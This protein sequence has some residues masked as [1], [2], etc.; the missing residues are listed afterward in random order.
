M[1]DI[2]IAVVLLWNGEL[3]YQK[4]YFINPKMHTEE[5]VLFCSDY[6]EEEI[7]NK[8]AYHTWNYSNRGPESQGWY[9]KNKKGM[10][11]GH[12]C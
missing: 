9:L 10:L 7:R 11:I 12:I 5:Q 3:D 6:F 4:H 1:K 2:V 8:I